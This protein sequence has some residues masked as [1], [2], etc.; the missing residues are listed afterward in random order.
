MEPIIISID[1]NI[2]AGKSTF[3]HQLKEKFP[4]FHFIDEPV[5][6]WTNFKN[7]KGESL[8]EVYYKDK[9]RWS[10]SFQNCVFLTRIHNLYKTIAK[11]RS[12][13]EQ[14]E[15]KYKNNI[16]ITERCVETDF[17]IFAKMLHDD[18]F[19]NKIEWD[20][21]KQ[22]YVY[23]STGYNINGIIYITCPP[24][25]CL[26]RIGIRSRNGEE[27]IPIDY[28]N[29]LYNY[30]EDWVNNTATPVL[31]INT[32]NETKIEENKILIFISSLN[33]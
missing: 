22:W 9:E 15:T 24:E 1:G 17:R 28:L 27:N 10:F 26:E 21:Y 11:W 31:I 16:F 8:L 25:K 7:D 20:I 6:I 5:D 14:D 33:Y 29:K 4:N 12:E 3:L 18:G 30:H 32:Q 2:G 13:C 23:L 19:I